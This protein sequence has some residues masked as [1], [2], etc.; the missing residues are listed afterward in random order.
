VIATGVMFLNLDVRST[1]HNFEP[2]F[3][4]GLQLA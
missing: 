1:L 3:R 4:S 2:D